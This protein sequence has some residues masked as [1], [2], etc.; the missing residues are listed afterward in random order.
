MHA[1]HDRRDAVRQYT[2]YRRVLSF[3][4]AWIW[5]WTTQEGPDQGRHNR[6]TLGPGISPAGDAGRYSSG[7]CKLG[8]GNDAR[9][10]RKDRIRHTLAGWY[11]Y[12]IRIQIQ[13]MTKVPRA[14]RGREMNCS[15]QLCSGDRPADRYKHM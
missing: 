7:R 6:T 15:A 10:H 14:D 1:L 5:T 3:D 9:A 8:L 4:P 11:A 12:G 2:F 13:V